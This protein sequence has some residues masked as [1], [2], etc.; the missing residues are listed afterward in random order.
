[1]I[2]PVRLASD[3]SALQAVKGGDHAQH[4]LVNEGRDGAGD[5]SARSDF[6]SYSQEDHVVAGGGDFRERHFPAQPGWFRARQPMGNTFGRLVRKH[7]RS[8][9]DAMTYNPGRHA[10]RTSL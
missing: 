7:C 1:M 3:L 9:G 6:A 2:C 4:D 8:R 5:E 10:L